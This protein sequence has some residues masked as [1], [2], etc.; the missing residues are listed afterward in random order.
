M[1]NTMKKNTRISKVSL[2]RGTAAKRAVINTLRPLILVIVLRGRMTL[3]DL[4]AES[5]APELPSVLGPISY[6]ISSLPS[7]FPK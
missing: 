6:T 5:S 3:N 2:S 1:E 4:S 7:L